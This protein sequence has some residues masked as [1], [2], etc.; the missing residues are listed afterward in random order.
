MQDKEL[1]EG[2]GQVQERVQ[3]VQDAV[4]EEEG[5]EEVREDLLRGASLRLWSSS[6][7]CE[8][9]SCPQVAVTT[10]T[11]V[12]RALRPAKNEERLVGRARQRLY[13]GRVGSVGGLGAPCRR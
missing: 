1:R 10:L 8:T 11:R 7:L 5:E 13:W 6:F 3:E 9:V 4:Q 12:Q 2:Q